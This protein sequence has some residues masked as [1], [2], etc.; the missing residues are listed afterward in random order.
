MVVRVR[1]GHDIHDADVDKIM[2]LHLDVIRDKHG[3]EVVSEIEKKAVYLFWI[4]EKRMMLNHQRL[5]ELTSDDNPAAIIRPW[6]HGQGT[7]QCVK[8]HFIGDQPSSL[9]IFISAKECIQGSN[10][11][12]QWGLL[13]GAC[14][15]VEEIVFQ[16]RKNPNMGHH[17]K[18]VVV[19][20]PQYLGPKWDKE[21]P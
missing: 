13:N 10:F 20:F 11:W 18:Y 9:L 16:T 7:K 4:N 8:S 14:G 2:S 19:N 15:T 1:L 12:P 6:G 21:S 5:L 17:P 3:P